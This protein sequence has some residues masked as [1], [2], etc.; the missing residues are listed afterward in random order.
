MTNENPALKTDMTVVPPR[1]APTKRHKIR[2]W[3]LRLTLLLAILGPLVFVVAAV[4]YKLGLFGLG[5]SFGLLNL[6]L[7][8]LALAASMGF[9]IISM[10]LAWFIK[11]HKGFIVAAIAAIIP[12]LGV[13]KL[14][15]TRATVAELPFIHDVT[16]D[17]QDPPMFTQAILSE[18]A[19]VEGVNSADYVG[20][21]DS[22]DEELVSV[23]Q[24]KAYPDI[25]PIVLSEPKDVVF[26]RV[27][28]VVAQMGWEMKSSDLDTGIIEATD[29]TF[30]YGFK[31]DVI[32]R[33]RD[34]EGGG[35]LIDMRSL[36]RV[37]GSDIG[38]NAD[39]IR[40]F[41]KALNES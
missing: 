11:P 27:E 7:G 25:R 24:T 18:R 41:F 3:V 29:T 39:R 22:R 12:A 23:L 17:T 35:T 37:G 33:L 6:K 8:P 30:W 34:S 16:T 20:K 19:K 10:L 14:Q 15:D 5:V 28:A 40:E 13:M 9:A 38:K 4:G 21:K 2:K 36:S 32:I 31:D 26:G 1:L